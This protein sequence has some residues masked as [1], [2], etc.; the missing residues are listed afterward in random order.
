VARRAAAPPIADW[1]GRLTAAEGKLLPPVLVTSGRGDDER[2]VALS[3]DVRDAK[4]IAVAKVRRRAGAELEHEAANLAAFGAAARAA[5]AEVPTVLA[6]PRAVGETR[7]LVESGL[8]GDS[9]AAMLAAHPRFFSG[10]VSLL[11]DWLERWQVQT[12]VRGRLAAEQLECLV[13]A[14]AE[15]ILAS[16]P[17]GESYRGW[18][19]ACCRDAV[20]DPVPLVAAHNDLTMFNILVDNDRL[21][22]VD[23]EAAS[24]GQLPL[25]DFVYAVADAAAA[26]E[27]YVDRAGVLDEC[28][29]NAG[30][31][32]EVVSR[33]QGRLCAATMASDAV[34]RLSFHACWL[35]HAV[36]EQR[37]GRVGA[38]APFLAIVQR[39]AT[40]PAAWPRSVT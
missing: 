32:T 12:V 16:L 10:V 11:A 25:A 15:E 3:L 6:P 24:N 17:G 26:V 4:R 18:L 8:A 19:A 13:V 27:G 9:A 14:P 33:L 7:V 30:R 22:V 34:A 21:G 23:W 36:N 37:T 2:G 35:H 5:G 28:F 1:I 38:D 31:F 39:L 40:A 29:G 20:A